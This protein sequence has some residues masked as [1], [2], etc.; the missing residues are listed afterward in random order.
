M[1]FIIT[2]NLA[3]DSAKHGCKYSL[4]F[5]ANQSSTSRTHQTAGTNL[6]ENYSNQQSSLHPH[7]ITFFPLLGNIHLSLDYESPQNFLASPTEPK[8]TNHS[9]HMLS[10]L[11]DFIIVFFPLYIAYCFFVFVFVFAFYYY[12]SDYGYYFQ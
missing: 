1:L 2:A 8:N 11:S 6:P 12:C 3:M 9:S 5:M 7:Y 10:P 4:R